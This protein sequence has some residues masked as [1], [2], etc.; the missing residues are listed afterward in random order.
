MI[1]LETISKHQTIICPV[2][3]QSILIL[4]NLQAMNRAI[5]DHANKQ[6]EGR[7]SLRKTM[8]VNSLTQQLLVAVAKNG[9]ELPRK[10]W[11]LVE[12]YFGHKRVL[13]VAM[14]EAD[15]E[16]WANAKLAENPEGSY[17]Y[18]KATVTHGEA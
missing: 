3:K 18:E 12:S 14:S 2:C 5:N 16:S 17:F 9:G 10:V 8:I 1:T 4:P 6:H 13:G 7:T 15:A 11:L